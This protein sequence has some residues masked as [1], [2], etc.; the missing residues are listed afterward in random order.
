MHPGS[1]DKPVVGWREWL[2]IPTLG[3]DRIKA[4]IDTGARTSVLHAYNVRPFLQDG[5]AWV[6]FVV[7]PL[8]RN[9]K[10]VLECT[11]PIVD[12]REVT[13]SSGHSEHRHVVQVEIALGG[14]TWPIEMTLT[15]RDQMG[16]RMLLGRTAVE[17]RLVVDPD[18]SYVMGKLKPPRR[19][20][21]TKSRRPDGKTFN[22]KEAT[23]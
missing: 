22:N 3:I 20:R 10:V 4:K 1:Y 8:Q 19:K 17:G 16:F 23:P 9:N 14:E 6:R 18:Q 7:H 2:A 12:R 5:V 11:A 21:S 15:D 13:S